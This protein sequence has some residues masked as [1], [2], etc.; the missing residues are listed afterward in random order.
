MCDTKQVTEGATSVTAYLPPGN[1]YS[2]YTLEA[3]DASGYGRST[4]FQAS[5]RACVC[6]TS[7]LV[8]L[9]ALFPE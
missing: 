3:V 9:L 1:W 8:S 2:L 4:T 7:Q 6:C 5:S